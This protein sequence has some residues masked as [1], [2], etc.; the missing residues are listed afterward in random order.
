MFEITAILEMRHIWDEYLV[1]FGLVE[2]ALKE[3]GAACKGELIVNYS[4]KGYKAALKLVTDF[5][6]TLKK[7]WLLVKYPKI[8]EF[9]KEV[10]KTM[11]EKIKEKRNKEK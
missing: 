11:S 10:L 6:V 7:W 8:I 9:V 5:K 1:V 3:R 2:S 4:Q